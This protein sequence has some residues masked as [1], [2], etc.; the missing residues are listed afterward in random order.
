M[1]RFLASLLGASLVLLSGCGGGGGGSSSSGPA[2]PGIDADPNASPAADPAYFKVPSTKL[3]AVVSGSSVTF[4]YWNP[5]A[6]SVTLCLYTNWNDALTAPTATQ[7]M[8][9]G[10]GGVW[11]TAALP[12]PQAQNFYVYKVSGEYVLDPYA[13]SMA[14]W[15]HTGTASIQGDT[16]GKG[17]IVDPTTLSPDTP[18]A[19][20][21]TS[22]SYYFDGSGMKAADGT[23]AP[24][25]YISNRDAIVYEAGIRDLT[26]DQGL[27][28]FA[29]GTTWG[30]YKGLVAMRPHIQPTITMP[31]RRR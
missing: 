30:T 18:W 15:M 27:G 5:N 19:T 22:A 21:G 29:S 9:R 28:A 6:S 3:G 20:Y 16:I 8:T 17:A 24:Y 25:A 31:I 10:A 11:S 7:P 4:N 26:V 12:F 1:T 14:Q 23:A 13:K 2:T